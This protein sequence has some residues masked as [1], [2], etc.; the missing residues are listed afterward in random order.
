V[1]PDRLSDEKLAQLARAGDQDAFAGLVRRHTTPLYN[2]A[3]RFLGDPDDASDAVQQ[4]FLQLFRALDTLD[5]DRPLRPWLYQ[6]ART[7]C[8]DRLRRRR[9]AVPF[10][11]LQAVDDEGTSPADQIVDPDP[12]PADLAERRDLQAILQAAIQAL[13]PKYR[14]VVALRYTT[15]L[16]FAEIGAALGVPE[17][18]AKTLFQRAKA[19]LRA[20][21]AGRL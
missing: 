13:P 6:C 18:T 1:E 19:L 4:T 15:E 17:N 21:L 12:L 10:S 2:F 7:R 16:T 8:L 3:Y 9:R 14:E 11:A 5:L 20:H